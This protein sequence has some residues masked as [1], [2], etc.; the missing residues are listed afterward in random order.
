MGHVLL[1]VG[2]VD[3]HKV[4]LIAKLVDDEVV[5]AAAALVAHDAIA[6]LAKR[7]VGVVVGKEMV[8]GSQRAGTA[9]HDLAHVGHVKEADG[10]A[11][12]LVLGLDA[13]CVLDGQQVT[14]KWD[15]LAAFLHVD[16]VQ[17]SLSL[18]RTRLLGTRGA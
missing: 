16:V 8:D 3:H 5:D 4:L 14:R 15:D 18:H 6:H 11:Y 13:A 17:G 2:G 9:E 12:R 1:A 10:G 7:H